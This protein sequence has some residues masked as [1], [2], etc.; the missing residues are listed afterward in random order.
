MFSIGI[1][2]SILLALSILYTTTVLAK[3]ANPTFEHPKHELPKYLADV[4]S[5]EDRGLFTRLLNI[6]IESAWDFLRNNGYPYT[7]TN[8][9]EPVAEGMR[10]VG[11]ARTGRYLPFRQDLSD[12]YKEYQLNYRSAEDTQPGDVIVFDMGGD[13]HSSPSGDVTST[14]AMVKGCAGIIVNGVMRDVPAFI[15]MGMPLFTIDGKGHASAVIPRMT[16]WD[17]QTPVRVGDVTVVPGDYIVGAAHG[18]LVIPAHMVK[19][20]LKE[21]EYKNLREEFQRGLLLQG[22][23]MIGVYPPNEETQKAFEEHIKKIKK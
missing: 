12:A 13:M 1:R 22:R 19:E 15:N 11:R 14:R 5:D 7:F 2:S 16:S 4:L 18:I 20:V 21:A 17:Y 8:A 9:V 6:N 23:S 10:I 3:L